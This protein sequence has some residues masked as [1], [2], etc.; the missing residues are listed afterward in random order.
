MSGKH[1]FGYLMVLSAVTLLLPRGCTDRCDHAF[2]RL[3]GPLS[4]E[5]AHFTLDVTQP[6]RARARNRSAP[7][8]VEQLRRQCRQLSTELE[9]LRSLYDQA[10]QANQR[11]AG[12]RDLFGRASVNFVRAQVVAVDSSSWPQVALLDRGQNQGLRPGQII[13][14]AVRT[15][16]NIIND[17]PAEHLCSTS[18]VGKIESVGTH[19][20]R[21]QLLTSAQFSLAAF[22]EPRWGR[23][24]QWRGSGHLYGQQAGPALLKLVKVENAPVQVGDPIKAR[25]N[26]KVLPIEMLVGFVKNCQ[27]DP[28]NP[29]LWQIALAP[30]ADLYALQ[31]VLVVVPHH[32]DESL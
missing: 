14:A 12:V 19:T 31:E 23:Q 26:P 3:V 13:L 28:Q 6:W 22:V 24:Q 30:A 15:D 16:P 18:I 32:Q 10:H 4:A 2:L 5:S 20:A 17:A 11:W 1:V 8:H 21:M 25:Y 29:L 7:R 27:R 9:N